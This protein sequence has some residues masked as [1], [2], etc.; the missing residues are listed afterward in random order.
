MHNSSAPASPLIA[1][2]AESTKRRDLIVET[3]AALGVVAIVVVGSPGAVTAAN[4]G[5]QRWLLALSE[6]V[7]V[8]QVAVR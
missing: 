8:H 6:L 5:E 7:A 2:V 1:W 3:V 4:L